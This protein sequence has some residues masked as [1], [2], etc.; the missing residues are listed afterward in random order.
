[1]SGF[2][3]A[4]SVLGTHGPPGHYFA[5]CLVNPCV[6]TSDHIEYPYIVQIRYLIRER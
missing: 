5:S 3:E 4:Y 2:A 6:L 1:M